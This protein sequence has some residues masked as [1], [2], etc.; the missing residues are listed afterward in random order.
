[1]NI[2]TILAAAALATASVTASAG[3]VLEVPAFDVGQSYTA[4][5]IHVLDSNNE[6][7]FGMGSETPAASRQADAEPV[8]DTSGLY[9]A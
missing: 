7:V 8:R 3:E 5:R 9:I 4:H 2:K 6:V 1:M